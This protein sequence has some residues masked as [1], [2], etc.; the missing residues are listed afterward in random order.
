MYSYSLVFNH[1]N[2]LMSFKTIQE[3]V[4]EIL[5]NAQVLRYPDF[6]G[7]RFGKRSQNEFH[8]RKEVILSGRKE[9][10][11]VVFPFQ[12]T[13]HGM[14][15]TPTEMCIYMTGGKEGYFYG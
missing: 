8:W 2:N 5:K 1:F 10:G 14:F 13:D 4:G 15:C 12:V 6:H 11:V 7:S 3:T 9:N